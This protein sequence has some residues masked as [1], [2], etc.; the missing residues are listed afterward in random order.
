V[1]KP[2]LGRLKDLQRLP[3]DQT[4]TS[5]RYFRRRNAF[6][7]HWHAADSII[8]LTHRIYSIVDALA[9]RQAVAA[10]LNGR[11]VAFCAEIAWEVLRK[12]YSELRPADWQRI[13]GH[14]LAAGYRK[15]KIDGHPVFVAPT[16]EPE[17]P[18]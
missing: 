1:R 4:K 10:A 13:A 3:D 11:D 15:A 8:S 17:L 16:P 5:Q 14:I 2:R 9:E 12:R 7:A 6:A 18:L